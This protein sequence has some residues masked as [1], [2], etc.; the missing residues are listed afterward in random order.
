MRDKKTLNTLASLAL[1][2]KRVSLGLH[3]QSYRMAA[4]FEKEVLKREGELS[5][6]NL[7]PYINKL[8]HKINEALKS[9]DRNKKAEDTL[10]YSTLIQNYVQQELLV[11]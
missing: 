3:R 11:Q 6:E 7:D 8:I 1:D 9:S 10:M 2:L 4:Q 5:E